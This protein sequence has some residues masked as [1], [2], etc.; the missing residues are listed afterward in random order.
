MKIRNFGKN[1]FV[2]MKILFSAR[3][4]VCLHEQSA[5]FRCL[6]V[7][8]SEIYL[9]DVKSIFNMIGIKNHEITIVKLCKMFLS[10]LGMPGC[11][12]CC[13]SSALSTFCAR[14]ALPLAEGVIF[15]PLGKC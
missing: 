13:P 11:K 1:A 14:Y 5:L 2:Q 8:F 9:N 4:G 12:M 15:E 6:R 3:S 10:F 7:K